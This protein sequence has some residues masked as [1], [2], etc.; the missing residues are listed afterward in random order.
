MFLGIFVSGHGGDKPPEGPHCS[1]QTQTI[2]GWDLQT[3]WDRTAPHAP[4]EAT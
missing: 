4:Q 2:L 1:V 3:P